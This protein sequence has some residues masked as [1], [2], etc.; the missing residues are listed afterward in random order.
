M[1]HSFG[2]VGG[3]NTLFLFMTHCVT[4]AKEKVT[5]FF[6]SIS[7]GGSTLEWALSSGFGHQLWS[8]R[9]LFSQLPLSSLALC[10][11]AH[12]RPATGAQCQSGREN[13]GR[14][15]TFIPRHFIIASHPRHPFPSIIVARK[16]NTLSAICLMSVESAQSELAWEKPEEHTTP[17][18]WLK[19]FCL[20]DEGALSCGLGGIHTDKLLHFVHTHGVAGLQYKSLGLSLV[21]SL[22]WDPS[23]ATLIRLRGFPRYLRGWAI[24]TAS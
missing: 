9:A 24:S 1:K 14:V 20:P 8:S 15:P 4:H 2:I 7:G 10:N 16:P 19:Y 18:S 5:S 11:Q 12:K 6:G 3:L 23:L 22:P 21:I 13:Y 17:Q